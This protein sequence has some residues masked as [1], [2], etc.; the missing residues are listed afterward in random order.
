MVAVSKAFARYAAAVLA[1]NVAVVLWGAYVRATG[2]GAGCGNHWPLC[3]GVVVP[4]SPALSTI[5]EFTHRATS[6]LDVLLVAVLI[7]WA[8]RVSPPAHAVRLGSVL[9]G[10]FLTTEALIGALLVKLE[11]VARNASVG[12]AYS[13][14]AHLINTLTLLACLT[15]TVWWAIGG[16]RLRWRRREFWPVAAGTALIV[17]TSLMGAITALG[18]TLFPASS[19]AAGFRQDFDRAASIF[20]RLRL[21]HPLLAVSTAGYLAFWGVAARARLPRVKPLVDSLLVL[22]AAQ[23]TAGVLNLLLLAPVWLQMIHLLLADLV[24]IAFVLLS[25]SRLQDAAIPADL[26][27]DEMGAAVDRLERASPK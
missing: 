13:L 1:Y 4:P 12:R 3:N 18:D 10:V 9:S 14:S 19:L 25:A 24:W 16:G 17:A 6:G 23:L 20:V 27:V 15:L 22:L 5:I 7:V 26:R 21:F 11:H 8:F 2:S